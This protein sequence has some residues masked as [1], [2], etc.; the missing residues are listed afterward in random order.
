MYIVLW[1]DVFWNLS[2][3]VLLLL[4]PTDFGQKIVVGAAAAFK[5]RMGRLWRGGE[6]MGL[7]R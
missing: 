3:R 4:T 1:S 2:R 7:M 5:L 6:K